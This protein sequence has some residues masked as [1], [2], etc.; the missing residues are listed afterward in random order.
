MMQGE[1]YKRAFNNATNK[2]LFE[3]IREDF[4]EAYFIK[5]LDAAEKHVKYYDTLNK[6]HLAGLEE[7]IGELRERKVH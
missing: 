7:I 3:S 6:G 1:T 5:A 4:G 2:Y